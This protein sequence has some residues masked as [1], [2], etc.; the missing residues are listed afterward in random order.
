[1]YI[2]PKR[3]IKQHTCG[4]R[5][6]DP[7]GLAPSFSALLADHSSPRAGSS[8]PISKWKWGRGGRDGGVEDGE[9]GRAAVRGG[10]AA[11]LRQRIQRV[12]ADAAGGG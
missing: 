4:I 11:F 12:L 9:E 2:L 5:K 8:R 6:H 3:R 10:R 7:A 1:M